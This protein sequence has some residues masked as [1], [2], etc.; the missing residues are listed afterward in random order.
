MEA[1]AA[2]ISEALAKTDCHGTSSQR[3]KKLT[4]RRVHRERGASR[5]RDATWYRY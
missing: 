1:R 3:Q 4:Q 2:H 5:L